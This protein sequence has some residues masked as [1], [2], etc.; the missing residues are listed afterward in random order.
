MKFIDIDSTSQQRRVPSGL[1]PCGVS[2]SSSDDQEPHCRIPPLN[3]K[4][5]LSPRMVGASITVRMSVQEAV[6]SVSKPSP[7]LIKEVSKVLR[8]NMIVVECFS[9]DFCF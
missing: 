3:K 8:F 5:T 1:V 2:I 7:Q 4:L 6:D 9:V